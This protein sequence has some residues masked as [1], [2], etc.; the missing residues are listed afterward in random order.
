[1]LSETK[2]TNPE[3]LIYNLVEWYFLSQYPLSFKQQHC[4][5][6]HVEYRCEICNL[7]TEIQF[8]SKSN[9][10]IEHVSPKHF[11]NAV[12]LHISKRVSEEADICRCN[13]LPHISV[14]YMPEFFILKVPG[15][16][17][18]IEKLYKPF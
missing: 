10:R 8:T 6:A 16:A 14:Y 3:T 18:G 5:A 17:E 15:R 1:M 4:I 12:N 11:E 9:F 13:I 2:D 7:S